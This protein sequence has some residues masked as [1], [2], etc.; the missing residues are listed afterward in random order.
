MNFNLRKL[1][2]SLGAYFAFCNIPKDWKD[3]EQ[4]KKFLMSNQ[5]MLIWLVKL[6]NM[7]VADNFAALY[8]QIINNSVLFDVFFDLLSKVWSH[9]EELIDQDNAIKVSPIELNKTRVIDRI[10]DRIRMRRGYTAITNKQEE[11]EAEKPESV[12]A[13]LAL[14]STIAGIANAL[15]NIRNY[16]KNNK[17]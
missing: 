9:P 17:K 4:V 16:R 1:S 7:Q 3:K 12:M 8:G 14:I 13:I 11:D 5:L 10:K 6:T 15:I 2:L